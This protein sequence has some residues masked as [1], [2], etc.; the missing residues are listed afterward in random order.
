MTTKRIL[1]Q[2]PSGE[3]LVFTPVEP[4]LEGEPESAY[5]DRVA[6]RAFNAVPALADC[7]RR[8][9]V[10]TTALPP[11]RWRDAWRWLAGSLQVDLGVAHRLRKDEIL[12]KRDRLLALL[13]D[14][15]EAA[16]DEG[17]AVLAGQLRLKRRDLRALITT[18]DQR[19]D[20]I[21]DL[22]ALATWEPEEMEGIEA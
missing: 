6:L 19:L 12:R 20:A 13:R 22:D 17:D 4:P 2:R 10:E 7:T 14:Q 1:W 8:P 16:D 3:V 18:L 21:T 5:L 11:R 9:N 15:I